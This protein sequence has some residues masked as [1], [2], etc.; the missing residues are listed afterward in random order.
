MQDIFV[1]DLCDRGRLHR[2]KAI[3]R[4]GAA[5]GDLQPGTWF[6]NS[7]QPASH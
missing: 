7:D 4:H 3:A 6:S 1:E 5:D 2:R